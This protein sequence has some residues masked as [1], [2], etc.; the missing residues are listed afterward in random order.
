MN[1]ETVRAFVAVKLPSS[2]VEPLARLQQKIERE[3]PSACV[4]WSRP[5]NLHVTL[6]FLGNTARETLPALKAA[7]NSVC[8]RFRPL[9]LRSGDLG[10]FPNAERPRVVWVGL[11]G[12]V[13]TLQR[14]AREISA[15]AGAFGD[16]EERRPFAPHL[17]LGRLP[18]R[19][20]AKARLLGRALRRVKAPRLEPF[21]ARAVCLIQSVLTPQGP[22]YSDL[23]AHALSAAE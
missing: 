9:T 19:R 7:L 12:E 15:A 2:W 10:A 16:H 11:E 5:E 6:R 8:V 20:G 4:R 23:S 1:T 3:L 14:L 21:E 18:P 22:N 13:E 17:T